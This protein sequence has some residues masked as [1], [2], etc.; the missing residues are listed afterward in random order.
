MNLLGEMILIEQYPA[1][2]C[3]SFKLWFHSVSPKINADWNNEDG[4][5][6]LNISQ[7]KG[8]TVTGFT[9]KIK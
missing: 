7:Q 2:K 6:N 9:L 1:Y 8:F 3:Y 4:S 5:Y